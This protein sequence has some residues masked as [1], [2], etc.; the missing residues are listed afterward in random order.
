MGILIDSHFPKDNSKNFVYHAL[1]VNIMELNLTPGQSINEADIGRELNVSRTPVREAFIRLNEEHLINTL[2]QRGSQVSKI[3]MNLVEEG[4]F[5][6]TCLEQAVCIEVLSKSTPHLIQDLRKNLAI[7]KAVVQSGDGYER[8]FMQLDNQFHSL[9]FETCGKYNVWN[10]IM[11]I[12]T[13]F[14]R[15]RYLD[16]K[17]QTN[18]YK[19][20]FQHEMLINAIE[21]HSEEDATRIVLEHQ[22]NVVDILADIRKKYID[23]FL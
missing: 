8:E 16:L 20:L 1:K 10:S 9:I 21:R 18:I 23:Y 13:H 22:G 17:E 19:V 12:N 11:S 2:P 6:R 4:S 15:L 14:N 3:D 7:Q 5:M